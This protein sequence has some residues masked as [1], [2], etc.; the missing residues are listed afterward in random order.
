MNS[1]DDIGPHLPHQVRGEIV[2]QTAVGVNLSLIVNRCKRNRDRHRGP[3]SV[4]ERPI[5]EDPRLS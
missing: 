4:R 2:E 1:D 5:R 3:K